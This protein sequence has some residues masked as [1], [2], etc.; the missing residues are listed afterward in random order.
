MEVSTWNHFK[1]KLNFVMSRRKKRCKSKVYHGN[2]FN[3][4][5]AMHDVSEVEQIPI[6]IICRKTF[7]FIDDQRESVI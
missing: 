1:G 6:T 5:H 3:F 2:L 4:T 7:K